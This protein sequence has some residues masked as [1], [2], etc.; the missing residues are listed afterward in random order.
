MIAKTVEEAVGVGGDARRGQRDQRAERGRRAL[1]WQSID[2][3][4]IDIRVARRIVFYQ[5]GTG[6]YGDAGGVRL[7]GELNRQGNEGRRR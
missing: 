1:E 3:F 6:F 2:H 4:P 7:D 5:V